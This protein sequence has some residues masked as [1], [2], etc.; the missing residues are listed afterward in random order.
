[1]S[2]I[3]GDFPLPGLT[4]TAASDDVD[5]RGVPTWAEAGG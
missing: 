5:D 4:P 3:F 1:M 2:T